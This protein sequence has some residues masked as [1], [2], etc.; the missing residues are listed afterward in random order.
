MLLVYGSFFDVAFGWQL[1]TKDNYI[2]TI[3]IC[4]NFLLTTQKAKKDLIKKIRNEKIKEKKK[5]TENNIE[6]KI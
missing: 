2:Q 3:L 6:N 5:K 4:Y 1:Y